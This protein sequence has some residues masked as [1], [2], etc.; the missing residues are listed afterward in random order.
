MEL[1][2]DT[3]FIAFAASTFNTFDTSV[4][5]EQGR[6]DLDNSDEMNNSLASAGAEAITI[7]LTIDF[8][9]C[10]PDDEVL[11]SAWEDILPWV[12][13]LQSTL[14]LST[15]CQHNFEHNRHNIK[16]S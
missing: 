5:S 10:A 12:C 1:L 3:N 8:L 13:V 11:L 9:P 6:I 15:L 7:F 2:Q 4:F 14:V 16:G